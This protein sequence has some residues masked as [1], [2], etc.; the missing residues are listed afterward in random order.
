MCTKSGEHGIASK[1]MGMKTGDHEACKS[2]CCTGGGIRTKL[3]LLRPIHTVLFF[4][5]GKIHLW[6]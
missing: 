6:L 1:D 5:V 2:E 3:G 4:L